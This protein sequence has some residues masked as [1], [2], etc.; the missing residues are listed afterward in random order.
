MTKQEFADMHD[1]LYYGHDAELKISGQHYFIEWGNVGIDI[2]SMKN[3]NG[4]KITSINGKD[5]SDIVDKL[6][7]LR[8]DRKFIICSIVC[9]HMF[10]YN[11]FKKASLSIS[12]RGSGASG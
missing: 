2:F 4:T 1:L 12:R 8:I 5:R 6:F 7:D 10:V 11:K 3:G 9:S